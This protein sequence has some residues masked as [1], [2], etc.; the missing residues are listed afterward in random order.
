MQKEA[1]SLGMLN[2]KIKDVTGLKDTT[3][4]IDDLFLLIQWIMTQ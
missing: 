1:E 2:T 4:T 3:S